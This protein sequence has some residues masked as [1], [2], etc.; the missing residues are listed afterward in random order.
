M[1]RTSQRTEIPNVEAR[2]ACVRDGFAARFAVERQIA[3]LEAEHIK[4]LKDAKSKAW[5]NVSADTGH[6]IT[7]LN[8]QYRIYKRQEL[9][10]LF[11]EEADRD[12]VLDTQREI[13]ESLRAG[14][15]IDFLDVLAKAPAKPK[16]EG[17]FAGVTVTA[18]VPPTAAA[19]EAAQ[20]APAAPKTG[21]AE[22]MDLSNEDPLTSSLL[23]GKR[24]LGEAAHNKGHTFDR[25]PHRDTGT[26]DE[27][28]WDAGYWTGQGVKA[29]RDGKTVQDC[30]SSTGT[31]AWRAWN[32]GWNRAAKKDGK[33]AETVGAM[34]A[35]GNA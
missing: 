8:D 30:P 25:N 31:P 14:Q 27:K 13:F 6:A 17:V 23:M 32:H 10:K 34:A 15:T 33:D 5:K 24:S 9:A 12:T 21:P 28:A 3:A 19:P 4:P 2:Q 29:Y 26:V 35:A 20:P 18:V 7:D 11:E 22:N 16:R 1:A